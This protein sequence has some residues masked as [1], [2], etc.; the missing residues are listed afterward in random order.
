M[1]EQSTPDRLRVNRRRLLTGGAA[2][3]TVGATLGSA[4]SRTPAQSMGSAAPSNPS[5][6]NTPRFT[7]I[8]KSF[9]K[10]SITVA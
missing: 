5:L 8:P 3:L 6:A 10:S 4:V 7:D 9:K 1:A 2:A